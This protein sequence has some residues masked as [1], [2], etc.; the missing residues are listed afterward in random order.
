MELKEKSIIKGN[1]FPEPVEVIKADKRDGGV[2]I[3]GR[4]IHSGIIAIG[5]SLKRN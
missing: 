5:S 3:Y 4:L 1:F 2:I